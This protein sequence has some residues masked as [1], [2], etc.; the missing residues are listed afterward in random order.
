MASKIQLRRD[1][2]QSWTSTNP[3]L[4]QGEPGFETD[5]GLFK[6]GDGTTAWVDLTYAG[7]NSGGGTS[8]QWVGLLGIGPDGLWPGMTSISQDGN[9]WTAPTPIVHWNGAGVGTGLGLYA[10]NLAV[11]GGKVVYLMG[12]GSGSAIASAA[13]AFDSPLVSIQECTYQT[14]DENLY[15]IYWN[16]IQYVNGYF[17]ATGFYYTDGDAPYEYFPCFIYSQDGVNWTWGNIDETYVN[18]L[19]TASYNS[20]PDL[21]GVIATSAS[22]NGEGWVISLAWDTDGYT[23]TPGSPG[24]YYITG[25]NQACNS[26]SWFS[27]G[28]SQYYYSDIQWTGN[29]WVGTD[30]EQS[31]FSNTSRNP[32]QG[33]W[34]TISVSS[35]T[36]AAF[37]DNDSNIEGYSVYGQGGTVDGSDWWVLGLENG[38]LLTT[39]DGGVTWQG[40]TFLPAYDQMTSISQASPTV[41]GFEGSPTNQIK[42][43]GL[44]VGTFG[45]GA[46]AATYTGGSGTFYVNQD[47]YGLY[48]D[49]N[50]T[51]PVTSGAAFST[52]SVSLSGGYE[53]TGNTMIVPDLASSGILIGMQ[54]YFDSSYTQDDFGPTIVTGINTSTNTI[55]FSNAI[56]ANEDID[57]AYF[58]PAV[59]YSTSVWYPFQTLIAGGKLIIGAQYEDTLCYLSTTDLVN[60]NYSFGYN[61]TNAISA[62]INEYESNW[63]DNEWSFGDYAPTVAYGEVG[64]VANLL[65]S[66]NALAT[67]PQTFLENDYW[68]PHSEAS[69]VSNSL[70]LGDVLQVNLFGYN[71]YTPDGSVVNQNLLMDPNTGIWS[72]GSTNIYGEGQVLEEVGPY[73]V[74]SI[75]NGAYRNQYSQGGLTDI[76]IS[77]G[78][79][80]D[81]WWF[82]AS[83]GDYPS[84]LIMPAGGTI[85][86]DS[87]GTVE[88]VI[89]VG[90]DGT[91]SIGANAGT[92]SQA[93]DAIAIGKGAGNYNQHGEAIAIGRGA[94]AVN[95]GSNGIAIGRWASSQGQGNS[96]IAIGHYAAGV[97]NANSSTNGTVQSTYSIVL[98]ATG[99][100][101]Q[102]A[103][104]NTL[105]IKPVRNA[106]GP[107]SLY[108]N[109]STGEI[110]YAQVKT[111]TPANS[112]FSTNAVPKASADGNWTFSIGSTTG[113]LTVTN[114]SSGTLSQAYTITYFIAGVATVVNATSSPVTTA[115]ISLSAGNSAL[116]LANPG[117]YAQAIFQ[118]LTSN[119]VYRVT[120]TVQS[121]TTGGIIVEQ[122][123]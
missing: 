114:S 46:N 104:A 83:T 65:I 2:A 36:F 89:T 10:Y 19:A 49:V 101:V 102:D 14:P 115:S 110:T 23:G 3:I 120:F 8:E 66:N 97:E 87:E 33:S 117:D 79:N 116:V 12:Y 34:T 81:N 98:N 82:T 121:S 26:S 24:A 37:G 39:K 99:Q 108:Y 105:V 40:F 17:V 96:A 85:G 67:P 35:A 58:G 75:S 94:G 61:F 76:L 11:G 64:N 86:Y 95:Q 103:G 51:T 13:T 78:Y 55:T 63:Q 62:Y 16:N 18:S 90:T 31:I 27:T 92:T 109:S 42:V 45:T 93:Y 113:I 60:Y 59:S 41:V 88:N 71:D 91:I 21:Q 118:D 100:A 25:L 122:L 107:T 4:A 44:P 70:S 80:P 38:R 106:V 112:D 9:N 74:S 6:I 57:Y 48:S 7:G 47:T 119:T 29:A 1:L 15:P 20:N 68:L 111:G 28:G 53:V 43:T 52:I 69:G 123:I 77:A 73:N 32:T 56:T 84:T 50:L 30:Y 22:Y 5:T 72:I 54:I